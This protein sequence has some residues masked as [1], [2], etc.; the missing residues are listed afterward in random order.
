[1][2]LWC[3]VH[4]HVDIS[5]K[6]SS[7]SSRTEYGK[8]DYFRGWF[9][10][11]ILMCDGLRQ[12]APREPWVVQPPSKYSSWV[13]AKCQLAQWAASC[14]WQQE[15]ARAK[16]GVQELGKASTNTSLL[17]FPA[18]GHPEVEAISF[19]LWFFIVF[20][21]PPV[22]WFY[23]SSKCMKPFGIYSVLWLHILDLNDVWQ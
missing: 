14:L 16:G 21:F 12:G 4:V 13:R 8:R 7:C 18:L 17:F 1:M 3:N 11:S 15:S 20:F 23:L 9:V 5:G 19:S 2:V 6:P 10:L 22:G